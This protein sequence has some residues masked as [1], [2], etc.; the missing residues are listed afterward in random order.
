MGHRSRHGKLIQQQI[1]PR[2]DHFTATLRESPGENA[3]QLLNDYRTRHTRRDVT[4]LAGWGLGLTLGVG[5][6]VLGGPL[7]WVA[8]G[9][10]VVSLV[11]GSGAV[12]ANAADESVPDGVMSVAQSIA[13]NEPLPDLA[14]QDT[15]GSFEFAGANWLVY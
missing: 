3:G 13:Q 9:L 5:A 1:L 6:C 2:L 15:S 10:A 12:A 14:R 11:T 8:G 4:A 7:A